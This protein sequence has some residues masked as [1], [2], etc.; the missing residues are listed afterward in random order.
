MLLNAQ[1]YSDALRSFVDG[2]AN[3]C[4]KYCD[5]VVLH[6]MRERL[7]VHCIEFESGSLPDR[8][9][10]RLEASGAWCRTVH[11]IIKHYPAKA[12][13]LHLTEFVLSCHSSPTPCLDAAGKYLQ[14]DHSIRHYLHENIDGFALNALNNTNVEIIT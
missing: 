1:G 7:S 11:S 2:N 3:P 9:V 13:G 6:R 12:T 8:L 4:L 14:R 10:D 5:Y